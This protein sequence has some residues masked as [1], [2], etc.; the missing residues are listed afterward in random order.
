MAKNALLGDAHASAHNYY[1]ANII[2]NHGIGKLQLGIFDR[3]HFL[4]KMSLNK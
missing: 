1:N 3:V 2:T 4:P